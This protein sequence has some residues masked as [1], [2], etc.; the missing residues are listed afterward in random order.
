VPLRHT[1]DE[2]AFGLLVL[3]SPDPTRYSADMATDFLARLG[4]IAGASLSRLLP[5]A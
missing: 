3:S 1:P 5:A 2:R 4:E